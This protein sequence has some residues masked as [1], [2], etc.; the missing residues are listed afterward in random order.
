MWMRRPPD[1]K[2]GENVLGTM[3][4]PSKPGKLTNTS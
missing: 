3:L 4:G 2:P 1:A